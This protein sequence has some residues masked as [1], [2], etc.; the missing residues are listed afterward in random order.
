MFTL[1]HCL[2]AIPYTVKVAT[3]DEKDMGTESSVWIRIIGP[4]QKQTGKLSLDLA[5]RKRFEP[6]SIETFSV[7]AADVKDIKKIE[8]KML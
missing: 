5:Q 6:G 2:P 3:G 8:V 4:K 1:T 7:E